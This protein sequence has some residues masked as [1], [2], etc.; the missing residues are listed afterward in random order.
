[1]NCFSTQLPAAPLY[2]GMTLATPISSPLVQLLNT[3]VT[4][5]YELISHKNVIR[6]KI[7]RI[8][9]KHNTWG[10]TSRSDFSP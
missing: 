10:P 8:A 7:I 9:Q 4:R 3:T 5:A 1:V 2:Y 6:H